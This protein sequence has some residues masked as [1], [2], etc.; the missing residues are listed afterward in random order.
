MPGLTSPLT[1]KFKVWNDKVCL[2][3]N[4]AEGRGK[5][6]FN[7]RSLSTSSNHLNLSLSLSLSPFL[8]LPFSLN[9]FT[10]HST[11]HSPGRYASQPASQPIN[12][13]KYQHFST[14]W[15]GARQLIGDEGSCLPN[16]QTIVLLSPLF[17]H[18]INKTMTACWRPACGW[19]GWGS[20]S[21][22][23]ARR[24]HQD[25]IGGLIF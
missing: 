4:L 9:L 12:L 8:S 21:I 23:D 3:L 19:L 24:S 2:Y 7:S 11:L 16:C 15:W 14:W 18:F 5:R 20:T 6:A 22:G 13:T 25:G 10:F 1:I 17:W